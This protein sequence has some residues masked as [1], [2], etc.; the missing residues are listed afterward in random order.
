MFAPPPPP[1]RD[2]DAVEA[3]D[4]SELDDVD[5][6]DVVQISI[7]NGD[8]EEDVDT[9]LDAAHNVDASDADAAAPDDLS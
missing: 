9:A 4:C 1:L 7:A 8:N 5:L 6:L 3:V 2:D